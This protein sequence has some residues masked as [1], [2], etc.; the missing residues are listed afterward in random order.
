[1]SEIVHW[2]EDSP[3]IH[4][5]FIGD[6]YAGKLHFTVNGDTVESCQFVRASDHKR[7]PISLTRLMLIAAQHEVL[8]ICQEEQVNEPEPTAAEDTAAVRNSGTVE[9]T[10]S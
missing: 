9:D 6:V 10:A 3:F 7:F 1:M 2:V 4:R 5:L 8:R